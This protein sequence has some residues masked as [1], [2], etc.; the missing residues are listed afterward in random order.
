VVRRSSFEIWVGWK[1]C[2]IFSLGVLD[3]EF[4]VIS[5]FQL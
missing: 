1:K 4:L 2:V 5:P 3:G